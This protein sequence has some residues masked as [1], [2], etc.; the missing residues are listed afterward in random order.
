[1]QVS[2][3]PEPA[4]FPE[5]AIE[6]ELIPAPLRLSPNLRNNIAWSFLGNV[7][8]ASSQW[9]MLVILAKLTSSV[10]VGQFALGLALTAPFVQVFGLQLRAAQA[11]DARGSYEF[12]DY[13]ALRL[14]TVVLM[15]ASVIATAVLMVDLR[16]ETVL[17]VVGIAFAKGA[18]TIT[19]IF[20]G[21]FQRH[22]RMKLI[23]KSGLAKSATSLTAFTLAMYLTH[24]VAWGV[25]ALAFA[26]AAM[27]VG[28]DIPMA[29]RLSRE[30]PSRH[31]RLWP[32]WRARKLLRLARLTMPLGLA[33][34]LLT[35][36]ANLPRYFVERLL[37]EQALGVFAAL[38]YF[39]VAGSTAVSAISDSA[40]P[41]LAQYYARQDTRAYMSL[42][43]RLAGL[44]LLIGATGL[45]V[46]LVSGRFI[47]SWFYGPE[48]AAA[49]SAFN[50]IMVAGLSTYVASIL[51]NGL[52]AARRFPDQLVLLTVVTMVTGGACALL[53]PRWGL[54]G[55][56]LALSCTAA[57]YAAGAAILLVL[58][59]KRHHGE[60]APSTL[61]EPVFENTSRSE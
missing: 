48:Y 12:S 9:A 2:C 37:G 22:Q 54:T 23:A 4:R 34:M 33:A 26:W 42:L 13:L 52:I 25:A 27:L 44:A 39:L 49:T 7:V 19:D 3:T 6:E 43:L 11:T 30:D 10:E 56:A 15:L 36:N 41:Q 21:L 50:W 28:Y 8:Y 32:R 35:L 55:A 24:D 60:A 59:W 53:I 40:M 18:E 51:A 29:V 16:R 31:L 1:M 20:H 58:A 57:V 47:L 45:L 61:E 17:V 38:A 14:S 46:T 5:R